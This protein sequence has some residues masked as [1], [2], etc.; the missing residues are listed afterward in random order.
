MMEKPEK[1]RV[2]YSKKTR[3]AIWSLLWSFVIV[4][5]F[6]ITFF[7]L[8]PDWVI[9]KLQLFNGAVSIPLYGALYM[10]A[11]IL[12]WMVPIREVSF[13]SCEAGE[14][15]EER[16]DGGLEK[17]EAAAEK[18]DRMAT[19]F[20]KHSFDKTEQSID[21]ISEALESGLLDRLEGHIKV[22]RD[23]IEKQTA[24]LK[25]NRRS[26]AES[27]GSMLVEAGNEGKE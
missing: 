9:L 1:I 22:I 25:I 19:K 27:D 7:M 10:A 4:T 15:M 5:I 3:W 2:W 6:S 24:P 23:R 8:A 11:F 12:I 16:I 17:M 14:R 20:E 26:D 13:R 18:I 21:K